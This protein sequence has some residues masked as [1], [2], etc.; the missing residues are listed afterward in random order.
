[1]LICSSGENLPLIMGRHLSFY[2]Q[3]FFTVPL[4]W[5]HGRYPYK[6]QEIQT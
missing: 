6:H 3:H 5:S 4:Y 2:S 1:M